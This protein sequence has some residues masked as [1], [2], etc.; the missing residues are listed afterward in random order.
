MVERS[1]ERAERSRRDAEEERTRP[2]PQ[3][4]LP[5]SAGPLGREVLA[6]HGRAGNAA[7]TA[8]VARASLQRQPPAPPPAGASEATDA[9]AGAG[10]TYTMT[11]PG[12]GSFEIHS[13]SLSGGDVHATKD[14]DDHTP[15]LMQLAA[16]GKSLGVVTIT[17][18][19]GETSQTVK[20]VGAVI[21]SYQVGGGGGDKPVDAFSLN[22]K[23][24]HE[25][26]GKGSPGGGGGGGGGGGAPPYPGS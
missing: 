9:K 3:V 18:G 20:I 14:S 23:I 19:E 4:S 21:S 5:N 24:E 10:S 2:Q 6:A 1:H 7:V 17:M 25:V 12:V 22:G 15:K 26:G 8:L 11:V 13:F 16:E